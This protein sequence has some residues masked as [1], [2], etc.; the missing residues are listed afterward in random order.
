MTDS[1]LTLQNVLD[2]PS[3]A[4]TENNL[5]YEDLNK[6]FTLII[7][8]I[9]NLAKNE[10][11]DFGMTKIILGLLVFIAL[12]TLK[13]KIYRLSTC[14]RRKKQRNEDGDTCSEALEK[15]T[16]KEINYNHNEFNTI[17]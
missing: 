5:K 7:K 1:N 12:F 6:I 4:T 14:L 3:P 2:E 11:N 8:E 9:D 16:I 17:V 13:T 10:N 15:I